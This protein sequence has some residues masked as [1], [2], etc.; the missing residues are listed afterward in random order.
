MRNVYSSQGEEGHRGEARKGS[1]ERLGGGEG[2]GGAVGAKDL[3]GIH[4]T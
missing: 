1:G 4:Y 3:D 2:G